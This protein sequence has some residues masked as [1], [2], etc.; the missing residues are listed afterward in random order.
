[1]AAE[2]AKVSSS[3]GN[4]EIDADLLEQLEL[5]GSQGTAVL[6]HVVKSTIKS[7]ANSAE[8][9]SAIVAA[10]V[11]A[12][13]AN[14]A[15]SA[16]SV[17]A[18]EQRVEVERL[19]AMNS[20]HEATIAAL[21]SRL[22]ALDTDAVAARTELANTKAKL[23]ASL[24]ST[25]AEGAA[26]EDATALLKNE[27]D[28]AR[29]AASELQNQIDCLTKETREKDSEIAALNAAVASAAAANQK[30]TAALE[31]AKLSALNSET[32]IQEMQGE[33]DVFRADL[34]RVTAEVS[35]LRAV[36]ESQKTTIADKQR[37]ALERKAQVSELEKVVVNLKATIADKDA[38][39]ARLLRVAAERD[40]AAAREAQRREAPMQLLPPLPTDDAENL[41]TD[42]EMLP[43]LPPL[44]DDEEDFDEDVASIVSDLNGGAPAVAVAK[45]PPPV[46]PPREESLSTQAFA[47]STEASSAKKPSS[48]NP[49]SAPEL[50]A[51]DTPEEPE[52]VAAET[53][54]SPTL[55]RQKEHICGHVAGDGRRCMKRIPSSTPYCPAHTCPGC[56]A[57]SKSSR[58]PMCE[59][60][61][62]S[63][64][65]MGPPPPRTASLRRV[66]R[67]PAEPVAPPRRRESLGS[68]QSGS[69]G[70]SP[71]RTIG[72]AHRPKGKKQVSMAEIAPDPADT[73]QDEEHI[74]VVKKNNFGRHKSV[75]WFQSSE[76][77]R[78]VGRDEKGE[79]W[80]WFHGVISRRKSEVLLRDKPESTFLVR[81]SESRFG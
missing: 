81:V 47:K 19:T 74:S 38:E 37:E 40:A 59:S 56:T 16:A 12:E 25:A 79:V 11:A 4:V 39:I 2:V 7:S 1:M 50:V 69:V 32:R 23:D 75:K 76:E 67:N 51:P 21:T 14:A 45:L 35:Q 62:A 48:T 73:P 27:L 63:A 64:A 78:G 52:Y 36:T 57:R 29:A 70:S 13:E 3:A 72:R 10:T 6:V 24:A 5:G 68:A 8:T 31:A 61:T 18:E 17:A 58:A 33:T 46:A 80:P 65:T 66:T 42:D 34:A 43:E 22:E 15:A 53:F 20:Q 41:D 9:E 49:F 71:N 26:K 77:S 54:D 60:C 55:K 30:D 44:D 28:G